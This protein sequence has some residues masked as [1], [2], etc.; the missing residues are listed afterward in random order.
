[1]FCMKLQQYLVASVFL[2]AMFE[3]LLVLSPDQELRF[4]AQWHNQNAGSYVGY[5][6]SKLQSVQPRERVLVSSE[7]PMHLAVTT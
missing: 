1:M 2:I 5:A 4:F 6:A 7:W 3:L